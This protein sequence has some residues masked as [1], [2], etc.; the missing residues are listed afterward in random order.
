MNQTPR[1]GQLFYPFRSFPAK[2]SS[3]GH[4]IYY[5]RLL[6]YDRMAIFGVIGDAPL[7]VWFHHLGSGLCSF[8]FR[9]G[10]RSREALVF[11]RSFGM[12]RP[13]LFRLRQTSKFCHTSIIVIITLSAI[14]SVTIIAIIAMMLYPHLSVRKWNKL[15]SS[16]PGKIGMLKSGRQR[17]GFHG[18]QLTSNQH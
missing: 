11:A 18:M 16:A 6:D 14:I 9:C 13:F 4:R 15:A 1:Q 7:G 12:F 5:A 10:F 3:M 8:L 17:N 2:R